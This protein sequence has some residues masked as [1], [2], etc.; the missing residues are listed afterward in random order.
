MSRFKD[1]TGEVF[2]RLTPTKHVGSDKW[3]SALWECL[4]E[5]GN[6]VIVTSGSLLSGNTKSCGCLKRQLVGKRN[7]KDLTGKIFERLVAQEHRGFNKKGGALWQCLCECGNTAIVASSNLLSGH[8][9]SCGC[10]DK[11][12]R[13]GENSNFW[14]GGITSEY[15]RI[16]KSSDSATWRKSVFERDNYTC[17]LCGDDQGGN[18]Q[19]HHLKSF[20]DHKELRF[21]PDNGQTL[22]V[23]C[24]RKTENYGNHRVNV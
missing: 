7:F 5:C 20:S 6:I 3:G 23:T 24:H 17:Q 15:E 22:C 19:A 21:D 13:R 1:L 14:K 2:E 10:L 11:E 4:C 8:T 18:L 16:R 9:K 12:R